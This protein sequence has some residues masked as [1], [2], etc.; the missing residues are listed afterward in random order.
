[1]TTSDT[2]GRG[3]GIAALALTLGLVLLPVGGLC[4]EE[5]EPLRNRE[6][7]PAPAGEPAVGG[8]V[9]APGSSSA[10]GQGGAQAT[11][12]VVTPGGVVAPA[13]PGGVAVPTVP[14]DMGGKDVLVPGGTVKPDDKG[15]VVPIVPVV[16]GGVAKPGDKDGLVPVV[17]GKTGPVDGKGGVPGAANA[18]GVGGDQSTKVLVTP[19]VGGAPIVPDKAG[20]VPGK[21]EADVNAGKA[22][23]VP[24]VPIEV[25][26]DGKVIDN[27]GRPVATPPGQEVVLPNGGKVVDGRGATMAVPPGAR[28]LVP[29]RPMT[30]GDFLPKTGKPASQDKAVPPGKV[31]PDKTPNGKPAKGEKGKPPD[32]KPG[33]GETDKAG[34]A[35]PAKPAAENPPKEQS[36]AKPKAGD[37][38]QIAEDACQK[39]TLDFLQG[40]WRARFPLSDRSDQTVRLCF[41]EAGIGKRISKN[42]T[43]NLTC[44]A[45]MRASWQGNKLSFSFEN[46]SCSDGRSRSDVPIV[47]EGCGRT[48]RCIGSEYNGGRMIGKTNYEISKE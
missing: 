22:V 3:Y 39:H 35:P 6:A 37:P 11:T 36:R 25:P 21:P 10:T 16:P 13:E 28:V 44:V 5:P 30:P 40:C 34:K 14:G 4:G 9:V 19:P 48:T 43:K 29:F 17:P 45:P 8:G 18:L 15:G 38:L 20:N 32:A 42:L 46:F 31:E 23:P 41:N 47:C 27:N 33:K 7:T 26:A 12:V 2:A 1:M 24:A